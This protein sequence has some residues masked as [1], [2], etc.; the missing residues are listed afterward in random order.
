MPNVLDFDSAAL[1]TDLVVF[2][3]EG[4]GQW[5]DSR[6]EDVAADVTAPPPTAVMETPTGSR[7]SLIAVH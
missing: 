1:W 3:E 2:A 7:Y 5:A 6:V 4:T